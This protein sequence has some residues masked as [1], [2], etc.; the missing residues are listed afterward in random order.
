MK[1]QVILWEKV[2]TRLVQKKISVTEFYGLILRVG[3]S[4]VTSTVYIRANVPLI[5]ISY[6][7]P[8]LPLCMILNI[9]YIRFT[10]Y[11]KY[12]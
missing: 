2:R 1:I 8:S 6:L 11:S 7:K 12:L 3:K 10:E 9:Q 5:V 4:V